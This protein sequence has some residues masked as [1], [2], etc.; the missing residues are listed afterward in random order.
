MLIVHNNL[1][2]NNNNRVHRKK[3]LWKLTLISL[4]ALQIRIFNLIHLSHKIA[5]NLNKQP[6]PFQITTVT[7][8]GLLREGKVR[9]FM[10]LT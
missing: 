6:M 2:G 1:L 9:V 7:P 10:R 5:A 3:R 4:L 8:A